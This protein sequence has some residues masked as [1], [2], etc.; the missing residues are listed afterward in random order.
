MAG[1]RA[2]RRARGRE[3]A[4]DAIRW[5]RVQQLFHDAAG[6]P[7][8]ERLAY[9]NSAC[10][11]DPALIPE[12]QSLLEADAEGNSL[13]DGGLARAASDLLDGGVPVACS[14]RL[15]PTGSSMSLGK[16]AWAWC[17]GDARDLGSAAALKILRDVASPARR[18]RFPANSAPRRNHP[19]IAHLRPT[20]SR[21]HAMVRHGRWEASSPLAGARAVA[22]R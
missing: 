19:S 7:A 2:A 6:R 4:I 20:P 1:A 17:T 14:M 22:G 16:A 3:G 18:E 8:A 11:D 9:L 10:A 21:R 5:E 12:V 13:L 15:G